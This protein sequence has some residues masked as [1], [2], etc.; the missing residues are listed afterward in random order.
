MAKPAAAEADV[1]DEEVE[2]KAPKPAKPAAAEAEA[3]EEPEDEAPPKPAV[4]KPAAAEADDEDP[5]ARPR[6]RRSRC[7]SARPP[8][9]GRALAPMKLK[10]SII[11]RLYTRHQRLSYKVRMVVKGVVV[12]SPDTR[13]LAEATKICLKNREGGWKS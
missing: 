10:C 13:K 3:D 6:S 7:P 8:H 2:G 1:P 4:A 12:E 5:E 9:C 11:G